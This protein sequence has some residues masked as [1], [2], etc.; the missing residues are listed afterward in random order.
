[1]EPRGGSEVKDL[2]GQACLHDVPALGQELRSLG[3]DAEALRPRAKPGIPRPI[4]QLVAA[5]LLIE[6][7][8]DIDGRR[9]LACEVAGRRWAASIGVSTPEVVAADRDGAWLVSRLGVRPRLTTQDV[10]AA[11]EL[12]DRIAAQRRGPDLGGRSSTWR[13]PVSTRA[14]RWARTATGI[15]PLRFRAARAAYDALPDRAA[16]HGD[17]Y[18]RNLLRGSGGSGLEVVDWEF[19]G[20]APRFTDHVRLWNVLPDEA[21]RAHA[22][23]CLLAGRSGAERAQIGVVATWLSQRL[24]AENLAAPLP[25]RNAGDLAHARRVAPEAR[26]LV[27]GLS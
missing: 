14:R 7:A 16:A 22:I 26:A 1:M 18:H 11:L 24:V 10:E 17:L 15:S 5:G 27:D 20:T 25:L 4:E 12:A 23:S 21:L 6:V 8:L 3:V 2:V 19:A 13:A 9:R